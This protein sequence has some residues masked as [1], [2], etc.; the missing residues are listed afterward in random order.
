MR[1]VQGIFGGLV[2]ALA[3]LC[4]PAAQSLD[5]VAESP[6][7]SQPQAPLASS[8]TGADQCGA[9]DLAY[10]VGKPRSEIPVPIDPTRRRVYCTTCMVTQ[11]YDP[12]RLDIVFDAE[13]GIIKKVSCG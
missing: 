3:V 6:E 13:T 4:A 9:A 1:T 12:S 10:L 2:L 11:D 8:A 7:T 5:K